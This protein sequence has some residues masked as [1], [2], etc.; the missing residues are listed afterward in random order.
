[1]AKTTKRGGAVDE[2]QKIRETMGHLTLKAPPPAWL[3]TKHTELNEVLGNPDLGIPYGRVIEL[4][5]WESGGKSGVGYAL[6]ALGQQDGASCHLADFETVVDRDP[7]DP[8][9]AS[10]T[11]WLAKRGVDVAKL[12]L[13]QPYVG[14]FEKEKAP[15]LCSAPELCDEIEAMLSRNYDLGVK[16]Q[17]LLVDSVPAMMPDGAAASGLSGRNMHDRMALPV[18][19]SELMQRWVGLAHAYSTLMIFI[20]QLREKPGVRFGDPA[21][22]PGGNALP[23]YSSVRARVKRAPKCLMKKNGKTIG[24]KGIITCKKNK[25]G[26]LEGSKIGFRMLFR[27]PLSFVPAKELEKEGKE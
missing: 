16:K 6:L 10:A 25:C 17:I 24:L 7:F 15:R 22:T 9:R 13:F 2:I 18:F 1:M 21:Y 26:G 12:S 4:S 14:R 11:S 5:G 8:I 3:N 20:N 23:F 27:G 19:M